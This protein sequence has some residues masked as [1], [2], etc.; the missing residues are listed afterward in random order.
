VYYPP[1]CSANTQS[2]KHDTSKISVTITGS[3][4]KKW[5][6]SK[7]QLVFIFHTIVMQSFMAHQLPIDMI[8]MITKTTTTKNAL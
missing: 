1:S 4:P 5:G 6:I 3:H 8:K 2:L 7:Y